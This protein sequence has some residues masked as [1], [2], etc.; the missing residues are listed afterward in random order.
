MSRALRASRRGRGHVSPN[1]MVGAAWTDGVRWI[2]R[3]FSRFGGAH[4]EARLFPLLPD[5]PSGELF[6]TL[7]P[8]TVF[9]KTPPCIDLLLARPPARVVIAVPDPD[10]RVSGGGIRKLKEAGI[11]V[12]V[13]ERAA[14]VVANDLPFFSAHL[15]GRPWVE[16]K[17]GSSIDGRVATSGGE[18]RWITGPSA[19]KD[20]HRRRSTADA[21]VV[22]AGTALKDDPELTVRHV[23]GP[24][25][26]KIVIDSGFRTSPE[27]AVWK[28]W[29]G[30]YGPGSSPEPALERRGNHAKVGTVW[31]R[32][33]R[34]VLVSTEG[35]DRARR[36]AF[37][38]L[39]WE[40]W[41]LPGAD[42]HGG[43]GG[44]HVSMEAFLARALA[45]GF[46]HLFV[47]PGPSL[48]GALLQGGWVDA[49]T[50]YMAAK[51]IG[52]SHSWSGGYEAATLADAFQFQTV[53]VQTLDQDVLVRLRR[54]GVIEEF[55]SCLP[56]S[57][58][59]S[60]S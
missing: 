53:D 51:V 38:E 18:S 57:S 37:E 20:V 8:C 34:L 32:R 49:L 27:A 21:V 28:A 45:E 33:P 23:K 10:P 17:L 39:G 54:P 35:G 52:G 4:A 16:V 58:R 41:S 5:A 50:L 29:N 59:R 30:V 36:R 22:G 44:R 43:L 2:T 46:H 13:G 7:E 3:H 55:L 24:E 14:D 25:P 11:P 40:V 26:S 19:R 47:E 42:D 12:V 15:R 6:L 56:G 1:P 31:T 60:E 9:G 48:A